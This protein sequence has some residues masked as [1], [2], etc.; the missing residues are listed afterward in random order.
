MGPAVFQDCTS[1]ETLVLPES[2]EE[3]RDVAFMGCEQLKLDRLPNHLKRIETMAFDRCKQITALKL[4]AELELLK[5]TCFPAGLKTLYA[6]ENRLEDY[7]QMLNG[8]VSELSNRYHSM[9]IGPGGRWR[10]DR[11]TGA[12]RAA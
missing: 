6:P 7:Q 1:L 2:L 9:L 11:E 5:D 10:I 3:I 4:G 12:L 8:R